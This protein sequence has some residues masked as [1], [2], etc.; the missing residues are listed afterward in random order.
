MT[1]YNEHGK[2]RT[3]REKMK[4]VTTV[5]TT[6]R[7]FSISLDPEVIERIDAA[8]KELGISRNAWI[9]FRL[10]EACR[11][12]VQVSSVLTGLGHA[13]GANMTGKPDPE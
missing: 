9:Q 4:G 11:A 5:A 10:A 7:T 8:A 6:K 12:Q 1:C 3:P 2:Q 13:I